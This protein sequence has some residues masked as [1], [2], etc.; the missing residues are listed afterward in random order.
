MQRQLNKVEKLTLINVSIAI[1]IF[2]S[3]LAT[4]RL[5]NHLQ[6]QRGYRVV[7]SQISFDNFDH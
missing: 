1:D 2:I 6:R 5:P 3:C 7:F 4:V